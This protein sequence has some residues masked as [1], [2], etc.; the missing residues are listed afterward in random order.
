M[1]KRYVDKQT[2]KK[3]NDTLEQMGAIDNGNS[4]SKSTSSEAAQSSDMS[5][6]V[7]MLA[8]IVG[9]GFYISYDSEQRYGETNSI[10]ATQDDSA[11]D[12]ALQP[13]IV[14]IEKVKTVD[15]K[16]VA[17]IPATETASGAVIVEKVEQKTIITKAVI[18]VEEAAAT[19]EVAAKAV[20]VEIKPVAAAPAPMPS[21]LPMVESMMQTADVVAAPVVKAAEEVTETVTQ[22]AVEAA[23]API[24]QPAQVYNPYGYQYGQPQNN[25]YQ[26]QPQYG[27]PY[28]NPYNNPYGYGNP[29]QQPSQ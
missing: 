11:Q 16:P 8:L 10:A 27:N 3:L 18:E 14:S 7:I 25:Y 26:P 28:G 2:S 12:A 9:M 22:A 17:V 13:V 24:A 19:E 6:Y 23:P 4:S 29:Y 5:F 15:I 1:E 20:P 21:V